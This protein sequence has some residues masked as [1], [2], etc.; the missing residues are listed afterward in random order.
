VTI[1]ELGSIGEFVAA[2]ATIAT[3]AYLA[4]QIRQNTKTVRATNYESVLNGLRDFHALIAQDGELADIWVRGSEDLAS[5]KPQEYV[6]FNMLLYN[7]FTNFGIALHLHEQGM[8][9]HRLLR[10]FEDGLIWMLTRSGVLA[11]WMTKDA[12]FLENWDYI[13]QRRSA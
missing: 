8:I 13:E 11:W 10:I 4:F 2:I 1:Q 6:R 3:L 12:K 9:E 5:L 7:V